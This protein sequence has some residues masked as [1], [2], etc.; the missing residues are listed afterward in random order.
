MRLDVQHIIAV[1]AS[2]WV[3]FVEPGIAGGHAVASFAALAYRYK[4]AR[5][6]PTVSQMSGA[7][8]KGT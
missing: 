8:N 2:P 3:A 4:V 1:L 7:I 5:E 6:I